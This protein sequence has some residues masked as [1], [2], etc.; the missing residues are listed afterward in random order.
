VQARGLLQLLQSF[1]IDFQIRVRD[2]QNLF[3]IS[4]LAL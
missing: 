4:F 2:E 1:R 3:G